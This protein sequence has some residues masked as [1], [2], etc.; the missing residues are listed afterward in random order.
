MRTGQDSSP[1]ANRMKCMSVP[2]G[3][4]FNRIAAQEH[5]DTSRIGFL[6]FGDQG[7][8]SL[9]NWPAYEW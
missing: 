2:A 7:S 5:S 9:A 3:S 8:G 1:A 6:M 4:N